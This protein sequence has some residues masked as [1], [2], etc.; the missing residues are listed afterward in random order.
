[1]AQPLVTSLSGGF[2]TGLHPTSKTVID[3][4]VAAG[5]GVSGSQ[6]QAIDKFIRSEIASGRWGALVPSLFV[7]VWGV[8]AANALDWVRS[9]SGTFVGGSTHAS[10]YWQSNGTTGYLDSGASPSGL[11][12]TASGGGF[13]YLSPAWVTPEPAFS[14]GV[15][16]GTS[17]IAAVVQWFSATGVRIIYNDTG[18]GLLAQGAAASSFVVGLL[19][20]QRAGGQRFIRRRV[21]SG[22]SSLASNTSANSGTVPNLNIFWGAYNNNGVVSGPSTVRFSAMAATRGLSTLQSDEYTANLATLYTN[23][24]GNAL[25]A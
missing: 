14:V 2:A 20:F 5:A 16:G 8:A 10:G 4:L 22:V 3:S 19:S 13:V 12:M 23:L 7:P 1:M 11:G 9:S 18:T 15:Q 6:R 17:A 21:L 25:P 24:T